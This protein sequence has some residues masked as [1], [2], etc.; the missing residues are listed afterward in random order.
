VTLAA[1][2][3][4]PSNES[5]M[6]ALPPPK[7]TRVAA[8]DWVA[9][10]LVLALALA[11]WMP[12]LFGPIDLRYDAGV[13]Y[14]LGTSLATGQ[15]YRLLNE[16]GEPS[17]VQYPP[18]L[19]VLVAVHQWALGT[20]DSLVVG[21][22]LRRTYCLLFLAYAAGLYV[23]ARGH[24]GPPLAALASALCLLQANTYLLS[25]LLF[26]EL[27]FALT[28][29]LLAWNQ[30][31]AREQPTRWSEAR[32][33]LL[34]SAAFLLRT[35]GLAALAAW[36]I[37]AAVRRRWRQAVLRAGLAAL[38]FLGWQ[39]YVAHVR[40]QP[41]Y[42]Q[43]AYAYQRAPYQMYN[44]TYAENIVLKDP[45]RPAEGFI[46]TAAVLQRLR[47]NLAEMP[48]AIGETV[49][50]TL[51]FW[52][53]GFN[54]LQDNTW[55]TRSIDDAAVVIPL[56][57]LSLLIL[58]GLVALALR[59]DYFSALCALFS[60]ALVCATPWPG[61]FARYLAPLSGL[62]AVAA[63]LALVAFWE[64]TQTRRLAKTVLGAP[65]LASLALAIAVQVFAV[66]KVF[67]R[68]RTDPG[69]LIPW[70]GAFAAFYHGPA[71]ASWEKAVLWLAD[72]GRNVQTVATTAPHL[73]FLWTGKPAVFPPM[74]ADAAKARSLLDSVPV[75]HVIVDQLEFLD[76][77]RVFA[78]PAVADQ[79]AAWQ[80]V[81]S[82]NG[83]DIY[84]RR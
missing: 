19:P 52:K 74:E 44:V 84:E 10:G 53:W 65:V 57:V 48:T 72:S 24:L 35:A 33:W 14:V 18:G 4:S 69:M 61:Q 81:Y 82:E 80:R 66:L 26:A 15:G 58:A 41:S 21:R 55:G 67:E 9:G 20:S 64:R 34:A 77:S 13:Y 29:V 47:A 12:R 45:F 68:R 63:V 39:G 22:W 83:T 30:W 17:A 6:S 36:V 78:A 60:I 31:K 75:S 70:Q 46:D 62:F 32:G 2:T 50:S 23:F 73:C 3:P 7:K 8:L 49:S 54:T 79:P 16:P 51:G 71:W 76:I 42:T 5:A 28:L 25:D 43:P 27:P 59:G 38:P 37:E 56:V 40:S 1:L 11:L